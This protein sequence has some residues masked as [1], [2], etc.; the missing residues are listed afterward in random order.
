MV[1]LSV[2]RCPVAGAGARGV[3]LSL[4]TAGSPGTSLT[5]A[6]LSLSTCSAKAFA[7]ALP[8]RLAHSKSCSKAEEEAK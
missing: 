2:S 8:L 4:V 3:G 5:V 6:F 7:S 1:A